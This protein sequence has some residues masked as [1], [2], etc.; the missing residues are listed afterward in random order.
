LNDSI[1]A[2]NPIQLL[3]KKSKAF[4]NDPVVKL[5]NLTSGTMKYSVCSM[6]DSSLAIVNVSPSG[7]M[8][9][10]NKGMCQAASKHKRLD[11][12]KGEGTL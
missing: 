4:L 1:A 6:T 10:C 12:Q 7:I 2:S 8:V 11:A 9:F 5:S 3:L